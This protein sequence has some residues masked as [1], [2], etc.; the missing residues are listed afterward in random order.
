MYGAVGV[1]PQQPPYRNKPTGI[2]HN[3][4]KQDMKN[5]SY[6]SR[7]IARSS[8]YRRKQMFKARLKLT[9]MAALFVTVSVTGINGV[10]RLVRNMEAEAVAANDI[11]AAEDYQAAEPAE[12]AFETVAP[13]TAAAIPEDEKTYPIDMEI[14][15]KYAVVYD[16][17]TNTILYAKNAEE[18]CYPASTTKLLTAALALDYADED[19]VFTA[20]NELDFVNPGSSLAYLNK[21]SQL[22]TEM[23]IDALMLPSGNDA[24]YVTAANIGRVIADNPNMSDEGAVK[25]FVTMMNRK[26]KRI[27][28][29]NTHF[30]NPDG[31]HDDNHYTT[32]MDMLKIALYA[33]DCDMIAKS[34]Q[35][36]DLTQTFLSGEVIYWKNSN[37]MINPYSQFYYCYSKGMKTGMTDEAGY[38]VVELAE[39]Y[40]HQVIAVVMGGENAASR[41]N[42]TIALLDKA[43]VIA[44]DYEAQ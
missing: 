24:A 28:A 14:S 16:V 11:I 13:E 2:P 5:Y 39:R 12:T 40:D 4:R 8:A 7:P 31:F 43:F 26:A 20:G 32:A 21:G 41:W 1:I 34:V 35:K 30:A 23:M 10:K 22:S 18:K 17:T 44:K 33:K 3:K 29:Q 42:D 37:V 38:C 19:F 25:E 9:I 15:S 27:G 36:V 6:R